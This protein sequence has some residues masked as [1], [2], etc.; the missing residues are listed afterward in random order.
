MRTGQSITYL[1]TNSATDNYKTARVKIAK[2]CAYQERH[3][4][5][6][7]DKLYSFGLH[8]N[9]V[10]GLIVEMIEQ[11]YL[12]EERYAV[13]YCRGKHLL[14]KWGRNKIIRELK[15]KRISDY[16]I[17]RGLQEINEEVYQNNLNVLLESHWNKHKDLNSFQRKNKCAQHLMRKGYEPE[18]VWSQ[19]KELSAHD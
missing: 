13:S 8:S 9:E 7:R 6:V 10:E 15:I 4:Q 5:E 1:L 17:K 11:N 12:S 2:Y 14:K 19:I 18:L 3:H 16:C